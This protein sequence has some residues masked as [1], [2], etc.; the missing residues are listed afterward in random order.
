MKLRSFDQL[1]IIQS[2]TVTKLSG[3]LVAIRA[4]IDRDEAPTGIQ[5]NWTTEPANDNKAPAGMSVECAHEITPS[6]EAIERIMNDIELVW[7]REPRRLGGKGK[8][9]LHAWPVQ[10]D[11]ERDQFGDVV[12]QRVGALVF[13]GKNALLG[14][15]ERATREKGGAAQTIPNSHVAAYVGAEDIVFIPAAKLKRKGI[16]MKKSETRA[17]LREMGVN[18]EVDLPEARHNAGLDIYTKPKRPVLPAG[19]PV[20]GNIFLGQMKAPPKKGGTE[21]WQDLAGNVRKGEIEVWQDL[22][23]NIYGKDE[24]RRAHAKLPE[25]DRT[26]LHALETAKTMADIGKAHG[27]SGAFATKQGR[28]ALIAANDNLGAALKKFAG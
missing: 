21:M 3:K 20:V 8:Q 15:Q 19:S 17:Y 26:T 14:H 12:R 13:D 27:Y 11:V 5:T 7:R 24:W 22:Y 25:A 10:R 9:E 4:Y 1:A 23:G 18:G 16:P 6:I 2:G 28:K